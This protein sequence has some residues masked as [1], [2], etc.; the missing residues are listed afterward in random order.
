[1]ANGEGL[2]SFIIGK[3]A[4]KKHCLV[5]K[6]GLGF[7]PPQRRELRFGRLGR[8]LAAAIV[9]G[10]QAGELPALAAR[11]RVFGIARCRYAD[12]RKR[13]QEQSLHLASSTGFRTAGRERRARNQQ[14]RIISPAVARLK[15]VKKNFPGL[16]HPYYQKN[17]TASFPIETSWRD[18]AAARRCAGCHKPPRRMTTFGTRWEQPGS[19]IRR[20]ESNAALFRECSGATWR[21]CPTREPPS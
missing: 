8:Q 5:A 10:A 15:P 2:Q 3:R 19:S 16:K 4:S 17:L 13:R 1:I 6:L 14:A 11:A 20:S 21:R 12:H 7:Q 9:D 18:P